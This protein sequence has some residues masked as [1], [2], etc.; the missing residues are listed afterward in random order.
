MSY[1]L[2]EIEDFIPLNSGS[3][4]NEYL[5]HHL[6]SLSKCRE[7]QL[8][9]SAFYHLHLVYMTLVYV[10]IERIFEYM[11]PKE[12]EERNGGLCSDGGRTLR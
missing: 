7:N 6:Q 1:L 5:T 12:K 3:P 8:Y 2:G 10:Q 11:T 4:I 9:S